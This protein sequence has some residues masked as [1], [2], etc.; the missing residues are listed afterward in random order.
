MKSN[1]LGTVFEE[2]FEIVLKL[3]FYFSSFECP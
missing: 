1:N 2:I 3:L